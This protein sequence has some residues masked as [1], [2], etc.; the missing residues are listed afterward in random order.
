MDD[1]IKEWNETHERLIR[2]AND[3]N[4]EREK[5]KFKYKALQLKY[6][7]YHLK[8]YLG[9][10]MICGNCDNYN[11]CRDLCKEDYPACKLYSKK[12]Q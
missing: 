2:S 5:M 10:K 11:S 3:S 8:M 6:C 12:E 1:L 4:N 9:E 7:I